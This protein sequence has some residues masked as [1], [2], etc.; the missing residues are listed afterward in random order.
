MP[1]TLLLLRHATT[2]DDAPGGDVARQL[3]REGEDEARHVGAALA[4]GGCLPTL[5]VHSTAVRATRTTELLVECAAPA[6]GQVP[7]RGVDA[8]YLASPRVLLE[9]IACEAADHEVILV[10]AHN[11]GLSEL[12][13]LLMRSAEDDSIVALGRGMRPATLVQ[14]RLDTQG[15][16][17]LLNR[18]HVEACRHPS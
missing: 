7:V 5:I 6:L 8:L 2:E 10:V 15:W 3:T 14:I 13:Q 16:R 9:V 12:T 4:D 11:P 1:R 18:G 17:D